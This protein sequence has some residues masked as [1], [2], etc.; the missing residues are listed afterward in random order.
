MQALFFSANNTM[1]FAWYDTQEVSAGTSADHD[2]KGPRQPFTIKPFEGRPLTIRD[3]VCISSNDALHFAWYI[4]RIPKGD[5]EYC[6]WVCA[7]SSTALG[8]DRDWYRSQ[9]PRGA[10]PN[11]LLFITSNNKMHFAWF[12]KGTELWVGRGSSEDLDK[13]DIH[14]CL[15]PP[16]VKT[17]HI[18]YMASTDKTHF[19]FLKNGTYLAG[20]SDKLDRVRTGGVYDLVEMKDILKV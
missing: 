4:E 12:K 13:H 9:L 8:A 16:A 15:L 18:L 1:H 14:R 19:A 6:L 20:N 5:P 7:G 17:D 11:N 3:L 2:A 10:D